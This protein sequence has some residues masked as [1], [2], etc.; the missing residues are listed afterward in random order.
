MKCKNFGKAL[1]YVKDNLFPVP[2]LFLAIQKTGV[3]WREMYQVFNMGHRLE[4]YTSP[5]VA[6]ELIALA[7]RFQIEAR[8]VGRI[9]AAQG[10][11]NEVVLQTPYGVFIYS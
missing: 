6:Q 2:P 10:P 5:E 1:R 4:I 11:H 9:E 8:I 3:E 7:G